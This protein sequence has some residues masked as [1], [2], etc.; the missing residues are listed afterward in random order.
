MWEFG[1]LLL[2][3]CGALRAAIPA[4][5]A[6]LAVGLALTQHPQGA[7]AALVVCLYLSAALHGWWRRHTAPLQQSLQL[8][9]T[10]LNSPAD[11]EELLVR[12][13]DQQRLA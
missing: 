1:I 12:C 8:L 5:C 11:G 7:M 6:A 9:A 3:R 10:T 4:L 13:R 2:D